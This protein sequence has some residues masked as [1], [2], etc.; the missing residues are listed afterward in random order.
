M[1]IRDKA[2]ED[3]KKD[4]LLENTEQVNRNKPVSW[5]VH[6]LVSLAILLIGFSVIGGMFASKPEARKYGSRPAPSVGVETTKLQPENYDVWIDSYGIAEPLTQTN[7]VSDVNARV[8]EVSPNIRAGSSFK[9]GELLVRLDSRDYEIEVQV[10]IAAVADAKFKF[11][12]ETAQAELAEKDWNIRPGN[13]AAKELALRKPQV[14]A[15]EASL[16]ASQARLARAR[17]DLERTQI[18]APFDGKVLRQMVDLGQVVNPSQAIA[19]IYS[20]AEMEIRLPIKA[21]DLDNIALPAS[22]SYE[23][24]TDSNTALVSFPKVRLEAELG[25]TTY[26]WTAELVRS[27]GAF[28][29]ETRMLYLVARIKN[30]FDSNQL[31]P[32]LRVGQ[33]LRAKIEGSQLEQV[34][35]IPRRAVTQD[36]FIAIAEEGLLQKRKIIPLWTDSDSVIVASTSMSQV[37]RYGN[38]SFSSDSYGNKRSQNQPT[39]PALNEND[40][41]ILTPTANLVNGTRVKS[42]SEDQSAQR[43]TQKTAQKENKNQSGGQGINQSAIPQSTTFNNKD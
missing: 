36:N 10:A 41:L 14:A 42:I 37:A 43:Q 6:L 12:Q 34:Y 32:G 19:E 33:F 9:R 21:I 17:L 4:Q 7:L 25:R 5:I 18:R 30:P 22:G 24:A 8:I 28:D 29:S 13:P 27:E 35:V 31:R 15:A 3:L 16:K 2:M 38:D 11:A 26:Q 39:L 20:I 23:N 40:L 1:T